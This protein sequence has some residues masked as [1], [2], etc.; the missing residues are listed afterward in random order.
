MKCITN[1]CDLW[2]LHNSAHRRISMRSTSCREKSKSSAFILGL[3]FV[4]SFGNLS[5]WSVSSVQ[6]GGKK[7]GLFG[8]VILYA[9]LH[10]RHKK[11]VG[12]ESCSETIGQEGSGKCIQYKSQS[13]SEIFMSPWLLHSGSLGRLTTSA[14][15]DASHSTVRAPTVCTPLF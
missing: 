15:S 14:I 10:G 12:K 4:I 9:L 11:A 7:L 6:K 13:C 8:P 2:W 1:L 5:L 3:L